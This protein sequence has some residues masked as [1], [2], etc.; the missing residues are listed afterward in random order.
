MSAHGLCD[1]APTAKKTQ[2]LTL[3]LCPWSPV[4][5]MPG[6][7]SWR[8]PHRH[9][10]SPGP[11][12][13]QQGMDR[14]ECTNC[15]WRMSPAQDESDGPRRPAV[16]RGDSSSPRNVLRKGKGRSAGGEKVI[17]L[18]GDWARPGGP[19]RALTKVASLAAAARAQQ[20]KF[21]Q[22]YVSSWLS[23]RL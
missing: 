18:G 7:S 19:D 21:K 4:S 13:W 17:A 11:Q 9:P 5:A 14:T 22:H 8:F 12:A 6:D 15:L 20:W 16:C 23:S 3:L 1:R 10:E 2:N